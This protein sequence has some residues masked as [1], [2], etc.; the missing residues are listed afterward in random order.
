MKSGPD[1]AEAPQRFHEVGKVK[2]DLT[3]GVGL[4]EQ[5]DQGKGAEELYQC[6]YGTREHEAQGESAGRVGVL[7]AHVLDPTV[8]PIGGLDRQAPRLGR[9][10]SPHG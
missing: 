2:K 8:A 7:L 3:E 5:V 9:S 4:I 1:G 6:E 10:W